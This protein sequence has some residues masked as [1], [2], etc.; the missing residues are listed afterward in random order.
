MDYKE[1][2]GRRLKSARL[3]KK[4]TM[5]ELSRLT[6]GEVS[7]PNI[8]K[9]EAGKM[10]PS[11]RVHIALAQALGMDFDYFFRPLTVQITR[12]ADYRKKAKLSRGDENAINEEVKDRAER[13]LEIEDTLGVNMQFDY[14]LSDIVVSTRQDVKLVVA[15]I[16]KDWH[17]GIGPLSN[18][19]DMLEAH[20]LRVIEVDAP[21]AFDGMCM[22]VGEKKPVLVLNRHYTVERKRFNALHELGHSVM[23][24]S[25]SLSLQEKEGLCH[26]FAGEMLL[27]SEVLRQVFGIRISKVFLNEVGRL[28]TQF[29]ISIDAIF[30]RLKDEHILSDALYR[31]F[32][33][34][35]NVNAKLKTWAKTSTYL[36]EETS[37]RFSRMVYRALAEDLISEEKA[38][39]I[40]GTNE[41][42]YIE[43]K[44]I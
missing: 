42:S 3:M 29:G 44:K 10:M 41:I 34:K 5:D 17:L 19:I 36:G 1:L 21:D 2:F 18:I 28:Q 20:G 4:L 25:D 33:I 32:Y 9:Y 11:S 38:N 43:C 39:E 31:Q 12:P 40:L 6:H 14:D 30:H 35:Q 24:M 7:K 27:S 26:Y 15:R 23:R 13:Y 16:R 37:Y 8:S 22:F